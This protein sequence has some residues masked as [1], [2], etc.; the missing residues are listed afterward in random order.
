MVIYSREEVIKTS[1]RKN[2]IG[3]GSKSVRYGTLALLKV[4][5]HASRKLPKVWLS[6]TCRCAVQNIF[7]EPQIAE[8][9]WGKLGKYRSKCAENPM[10]DVVIATDAPFLDDLEDGAARDDGLAKTA[11]SLPMVGR[12]VIAFSTRK[13]CGTSILQN[14]TLENPK[15]R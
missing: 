1:N 7:E 15:P 4:D 3:A 8:Y 9:L 6:Y 13:V 2:R 14:G 10:A 5:R 12:L 11:E